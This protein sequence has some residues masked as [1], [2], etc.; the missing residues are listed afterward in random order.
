MRIHTLISKKAMSGTLS[1]LKKRP[2]IFSLVIVVFFFTSVFFVTRGV[3]PY[4]SELSYIEKSVLGENSGSVI[5]ASCD[6]GTPHDGE[7]CGAWVAADC[8]SWWACG[9]GTTYIPYTCQGANTAPGCYGSAPA[10]K[11]CTPNPCPA[12]VGVSFGAAA[13]RPPVT[14]NF[15]T[16]KT[17]VPYGETVTATW[18]APNASRCLVSLGVN[19][20]IQGPSGSY[21]T[22][23]RTD[24]FSGDN[25]STFSIECSNG[26]SPVSGPSISV[27]FE[28]DPTPPGDFEGGGGC[29]VAGTKVLLGDGSYKN[30]EDV[31]AEDTLMS[32]AGPE[33][34]MK[35]YH[36]PYKG[37]VFAFNG[38]GNY[39]VTPTLQRNALHKKPTGRQYLL[40]PKGIFI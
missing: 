20:S 13:T 28:G 27:T 25:S 1:F 40:V 21:T 26:D 36:I 34:I 8:P 38:D 3:A 2:T 23:A 31:A 33:T 10:D 5:P 32:S 29:F 22:P 39:F 24:S 9:G 17:Y 16:N 6:S 7:V 12:W 37:P 30:I 11:V 35:R 19:S 18:S 14:V 4:D 15:S